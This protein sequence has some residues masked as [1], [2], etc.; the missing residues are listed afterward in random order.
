MGPL[1]PHLLKAGASPDATIERLKS[2]TRLLIEWNRGVSNLIGRNDEQRVVERHIAESIEPAAW[3]G[4]D[5]GPVAGL[6][7]RRRL[8]A[9]P[10]ALAGWARAGPW[11]SP[12]A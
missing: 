3:L 5:R 4:P 1:T 10:L 9:L 8:P 6:W 11:S 2:Y 7:I 12:D